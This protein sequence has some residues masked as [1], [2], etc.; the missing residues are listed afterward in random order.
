[1]KRTEPRA[2]NCGFFALDDLHD[3]TEEQLYDKLM[4]EYPVWI[5]ETTAKGIIR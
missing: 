2:D 5:K 1:M 3:V 4:A